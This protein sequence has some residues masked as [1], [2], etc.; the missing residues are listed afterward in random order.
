MPKNIQY[1]LLFAFF[2]GGIG[3]LIAPLI[4]QAA[5]SSSLDLSNPL[6]TTTTIP[7]LAYKI[8]AFLLKLA[9][10]IAAIMIVW[11]GFLYV[12]SAGNEKKIQSA[13]KTLIWAIIGLAVVVIAQSVPGMVQ[14]FLNAP[15]PNSTS[16]QSQ[17]DNSINNQN[18]IG[19][20]SSL[21]VPA[22]P[23]LEQ[24]L[25]GMKWNGTTCVWD[26]NALGDGA[27]CGQ[28]GI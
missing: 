23:N 21:N 1:L 16:T 5:A 4:I 7:Q 3:L 25:G 28:I 8:L 24:S 2:L 17:I 26:P 19:N 12:T 11:A 13:Q 10:P 18:S 22:A 9:V 15:A 6:G 27:Q 14:D 20:N